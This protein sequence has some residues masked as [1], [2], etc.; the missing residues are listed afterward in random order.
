[1]QVTVIDYKAGN[2]TSVLKALRYL[3]EDAVVTDSDLSL[4]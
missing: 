4:I 2:L 3:G 1:M